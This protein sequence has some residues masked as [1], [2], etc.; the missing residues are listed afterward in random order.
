MKTIEEITGSNRNFWDDQEPEVGHFERFSV[1]LELRRQAGIPKRSI[2]PYLLR[3]AVVT[4]LVTLSSLWT[5]DHFIRSDSSRMSLSEVS[6]QYK[7][8][9]NYYIHQV[10]LMEEEIVN[11]DVHNNTRTERYAHQ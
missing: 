4:L 2:V 3:A 7:E 6:P 11:T 9:E 10:N 1:K 5:W 8:V